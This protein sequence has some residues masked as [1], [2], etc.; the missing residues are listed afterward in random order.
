MA[1]EHRGDGDGLRRRRPRTTMT[2]QL[3]TPTG[4]ARA[5]SELRSRPTV[6]WM[7]LIVLGVFG[8]AAILFAAPWGAGLGGDSYY[9]VSGARNLLAGL[10]FS[11]PAADGGLRI[12]THYPP[13]YSAVLAVLTGLG[14]ET[15]VAARWLGAVLRSEEHTSELQSQSNLVCRLLL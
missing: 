7:G 4:R 11:R 6:A 10:G 1:S 2:A 13:G 9:Y 15:L 12:I 3:E 14:L 5:A 8:A